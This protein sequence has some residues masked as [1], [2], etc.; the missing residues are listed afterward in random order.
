MAS[1]KGFTKIRGSLG[2]T[3]FLETKNGAQARQK[4][5][6]IAPQ[7]KSSPAF[8]RTRENNSEFG[9]ACQAAKLIKT[10]LASLVSTAKGSN[11][12][13]LLVKKMM[14][15]IKKDMVSP[16]G[17]RNVMDGPLKDLEQFELNDKATMEA[18]LPITL[19]SAINRLTGVLSLTIP[20]FIPEAVLS[21]PRGAT[22]FRL[23]SIGVELEV[24]AQ[25]FISESKEGLPIALNKT[26]TAAITVDH[27]V[28]PASTNPLLLACGIQF[29]QLVGGEMNPFLAASKN[30]VT[31]LKVNQL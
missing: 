31:I 1:Q 28:T 27:T 21:F 2:D 30:A 5:R 3:T 17:Q 29:F 16:R 24:E 22:H 23:V 14:S 7:I 11:N 4:A 26:A 25:K 10:A 20:S 6:S 18:V 9:R 8:A 12:S 19:Q 15:I 13:G